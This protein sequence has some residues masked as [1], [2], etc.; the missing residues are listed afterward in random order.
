MIT[1][2]VASIDQ[3]VK[4]FEA[5]PFSIGIDVHKRSYHVA[6]RR[7]DGKA[8]TWVWPADPKGFVKQIHRLSI[9]V[10]A[11]AYEAGP[12][13]FGL[14]RAL[15]SSGIETLMAAPSQDSSIGKCQGKDRP[16]RLPTTGRLCRQGPDQTHCRSHPPSKRLSGACR[17]DA[18]SAS[19]GFC[20]F[21]VYPKRRRPNAGAGMNSVSFISIA[22]SFPKSV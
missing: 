9:R 2:R 22:I 1:K 13:G 16:T 11:V 20:S 17:G 5:Q 6:I 21:W 15:R 19:K 10:S 8:V 18:S 4:D 14:A 3:F 7:A 12:M